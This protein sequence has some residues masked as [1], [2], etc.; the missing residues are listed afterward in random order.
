METLD[1]RNL[2]AVFSALAAAGLGGSALA[3]DDPAANRLSTC[4][5]LHYADLPVR[6]FPNGGEQRRVAIGT[7]ATGEFIEV[8]ETMLP[9]GQTPHVPHKHPNSEMVFI[10]TGNLVH[11]DED[12]GTTA[13]GPGDIIF[14]ASNKMHDLKNVGATPATYIV[15]SVSKQLPEG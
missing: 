11:I 2:F 15:V 13:V 12:T 7:L 10:Q 14:T 8:H 6:K 1:R 4:K 3:A 9:A 5:V